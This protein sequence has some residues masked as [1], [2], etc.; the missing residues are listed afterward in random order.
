MEIEKVIVLKTLKSGKTTW[1]KGKEIF[2]PLPPDIQQEVDLGLDTVK[3]LYVGN[4][5]PRRLPS[6]VRKDD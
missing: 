4:R 6:S 1:E 3:A 5:K 2:P